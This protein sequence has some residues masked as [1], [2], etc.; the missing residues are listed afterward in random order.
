LS[1]EALAKVENSKA[2]R[3]IRLRGFSSG[4]A[5][6]RFRPITDI[7]RDGRL[8][9]DARAEGEKPTLTLTLETYR[10]VTWR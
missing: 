5:D 8:L 2:P 6:V 9:A 1:A 10:S 7:I 4:S 3:A